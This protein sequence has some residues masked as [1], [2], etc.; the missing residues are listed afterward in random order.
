[1][2]IGAFYSH[3]NGYEWLQFHRPHIWN[4]I[5]DVIDSLDASA[6]KTKESKERRMVGRMLYAPEEINIAFKELLGKHGWSEDRAR[7][8]VTDDMALIRK[9][10]PLSEPEQKTE[11]EAAGKRAI[12]SY[13]Q[14]DFVKERVAVEVQLGK[15]PFISYDLFVKHLAFFIGDKIDLGIEIVPM[16]SMQEQMSSGPGYYEGALYIMGRQ[17]RTS[18]PVPLILVG[19]E[20]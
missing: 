7:Y 15:Y 1:M 3:L 9:T 16:K 14:T 18:P 6:L 8:W 17:G 2:K 13:T 11:I 19:I 10:V 20:P 5:E 4:E 12:L